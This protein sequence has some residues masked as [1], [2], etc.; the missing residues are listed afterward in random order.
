MPKKNLLISAA[1]TAFILVIATGIAGAYQSVSATIE[2][3]KVSATSDPSV[4]DANVALQQQT[5]PTTDVVLPAATEEIQ[6]TLTHQEAALVAA[7]FAEQTDLYSVEN[8]IY[9]GIDSYKVVFSTGDIVYVGMYGDILGTE[10]PKT[11][12]ITEPAKVNTRS[13]NNNTNTNTNTTTNNNNNNSHDDDHGDD[14]GDDHD[15]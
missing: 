2:A 1:L 7:N 5:G 13:A 10:A 14:H 6:V 4:T 12:V 9:E 8:I 11:V 3:V 15:D